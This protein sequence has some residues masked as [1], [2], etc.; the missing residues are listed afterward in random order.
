M[1]EG[2]REPA[3]SPFLLSTFVVRNAQHS[4]R[5]RGTRVCHYPSS[6]EAEKVACCAG[7]LRQICPCAC[8][9]GRKQQRPPDPGAACVR[10]TRLSLH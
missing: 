8:P 3:L 5:E 2:G 10:P 6:G 7:T 9:F 1:I 4:P